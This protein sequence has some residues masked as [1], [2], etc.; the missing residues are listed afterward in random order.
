MLLLLL[1]VPGVLD[2]LVRV[3]V[4]LGR[5]EWALEADQHALILVGRLLERIITS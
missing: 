5:D 1:P 3:L 2:R 4:V